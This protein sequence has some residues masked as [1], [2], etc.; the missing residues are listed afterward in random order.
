MAL[1]LPSQQSTH[2]GWTREME[3][4]R[5]TTVSL[6]ACETFHHPDANAVPQQTSS[7]PRDGQQPY[8]PAFGTSSPS[9]VHSTRNKLATL[10]ENTIHHAVKMLLQYGFV[11]ISRLLNPIQCLE[12]G[13]AMQSDFDMAAQT[14]L[15]EDQL[16]LCHP[17]S[18][19]QQQQQQMHQ[20]KH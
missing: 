2:A 20:S 7:Y 8:L 9:S 12:Y 13:R 4:L 16:N 1:W 10:T 5:Q 3:Q 11:I 15:Q 17:L 14:L 6:A 18:Q 19:Q